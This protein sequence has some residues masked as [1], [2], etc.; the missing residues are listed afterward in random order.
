[1][2]PHAVDL[3]D[4]L[5]GILDVY[6][7]GNLKTSIKPKYGVKKE[8]IVSLPEVVRA[9][10]GAPLVSLLHEMGTHP[11]DKKILLINQAIHH[12]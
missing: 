8:Q 7:K 2:V 12:L 4:N 3:Q 10:Y 5:V 6:G 11:T 9:C 1:M